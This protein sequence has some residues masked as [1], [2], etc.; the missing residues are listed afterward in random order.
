VGIWQVG[1]AANAIVSLAYF[2]IVAAILVPIVSTR[3]LR[4]NKLA[5]ATA[6][7]FFPCAVHHGT[8]TLHLLGPTVGIEKDTGLALRQ[9]FAMHVVVWDIVT[10][11]VGVYYW[12]LRS[13]YAPRRTP[14]LFSDLHEKQ[15]QALSLNDEV[16]QRL[17]VAKMALDL[18]DN[19]RSRDALEAALDQASAIITDL[20]ADTR[21]PEA[22]GRTDLRPATGGLGT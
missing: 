19:E 18:G 17:V 8:H 9:A 20:L 3:Q 15:R 2:A 16:V 1:A 22:G 6:G 11:V 13:Q 21:R 10:A 7:I 4:E 5:V 12:S 14:A